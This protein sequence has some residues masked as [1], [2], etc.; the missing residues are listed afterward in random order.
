MRELFLFTL[1]FAM[2]NINTIPI[3]SQ[4]KSAVQAF[5][6]NKEGAKDTQIDFSRKCI[7]VSQFRSLAEVSCGRFD[8][9]LETQTI[10]GSQIDAV[11][12]L[13]QIKSAVQAGYGDKQ[14]ARETQKI[15]CRELLDWDIK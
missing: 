2:G 10:F 7:I 11:P 14:A 9:A 15:F 13:S 1:T 3:V 8:D 6:G 12:V 5:K 4:I